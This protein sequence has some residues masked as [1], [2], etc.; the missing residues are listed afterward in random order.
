MKKISFIL[1]THNSE[2]FIKDCIESILNIKKFEKHIYVIDNGSEDE[3]AEIVKRVKRP[4]VELIELDKNYGTTVAR[5]K[6]LHLIKETD[7]ICILDSDTVINDEAMEIMA[8]YLDKNNDVAIVGPT[9]YGKNNER[10]IPYRRFPTWKIKLY[11]A[12]PIKK[13]EKLGRKLESY[14][15]SNLPDAFECDYLISACWLMRFDTYKKLGDLDEK[16][17][18]SP[19]DVEYCIRARASGFQIVHLKKAQIMHYYQRISK[20][21]LISKANFTHLLGIHYTLRKHRKF[22]KEYRKRGDKR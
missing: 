20:R 16:I 2:K 7:Y 1:L 18:Y 22:L 19:E 17:F 5:N 9:M 11:K 8:E 12:T 13:I 3:S 10:Q 21:R 14:D 6:G 15:D 4:E